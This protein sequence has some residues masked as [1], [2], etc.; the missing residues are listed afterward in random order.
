MASGIP[1]YTEAEVAE[2]QWREQHLHDLLAGRSRAAQLG[3]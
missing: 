2:K 3:C 1:R